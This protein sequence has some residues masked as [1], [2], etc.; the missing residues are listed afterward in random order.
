[1]PFHHSLP[2]I[3]L[4]R[5]YKNTSDILPK[6]VNQFVNTVNCVILGHIPT[7]CMATAVYRRI[8]VDVSMVTSPEKWIR[9][10]VFA[11]Y[12]G[13]NTSDVLFSNFGGYT[14]HM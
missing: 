8:F 14:H 6:Y 10:S 12:F 11:Q 4:A 2:F 7:K 13:E 5:P 9:S 3:H 1:M